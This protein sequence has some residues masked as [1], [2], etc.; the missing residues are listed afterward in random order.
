M[1]PWREAS[2]CVPESQTGRRR[3]VRRLEIRNAG[4]LL[5][6]SMTLSWPGRGKVW[7]GDMTG[8]ASTHD[9]L[10]FPYHPKSLGGGS[11]SLKGFL[12][13][14]SV[15]YS[16]LTG[17]QRSFLLSGVMPISL[18]ACGSGSHKLESAKVLWGWLILHR[19]TRICC[20]ICLS[21]WRSS[22]NSC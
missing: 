9:T 13:V 11:S 20:V 1:P 8:S 21:F 16:C 12:W 2:T 6:W 17:A 3:D 4:L 18:M 5:R 7:R 14:V 15:M 10:S 19:S 22:F